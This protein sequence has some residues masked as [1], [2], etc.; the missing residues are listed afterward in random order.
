MGQTKRQEGADESEWGG[1]ET[2]GVEMEFMLQE[3]YHKKV[4]VLIELQEESELH[5][6]LLIFSSMDA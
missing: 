2:V 3:E 5:F 1:L 6:F 4:C